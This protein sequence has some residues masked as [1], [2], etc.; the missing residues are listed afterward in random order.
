[1][2]KTRG[3]SRA[4]SLGRSEDEVLEQEQLDFPTP[5]TKDSNLIADLRALR[6]QI[7]AERGGNLLDVDT[8]LDQM[9][10]ERMHELTGLR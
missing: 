7:Q 3:T 1:M 2:V 8:V 9:R 5:P 6:G 10:E 4:F